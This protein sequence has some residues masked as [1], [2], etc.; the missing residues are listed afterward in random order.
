[1]SRSRIPMTMLQLIGLLS[2][3]SAWYTYNLVQWDFLHRSWIRLVDLTHVTVHASLSY[4]NILQKILWEND[5]P[6]SLLALVS[7]HSCHDLCKKNCHGDSWYTKHVR[8][9]RHPSRSQWYPQFS[10]DLHYRI[11]RISS[12]IRT[13]MVVSSVTWSLT[14]SSSSFPQKSLFFGGGKVP[15]QWQTPPSLRGLGSVDKSTRD[16]FNDVSKY[17]CT[18]YY[19]Y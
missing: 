8:E 10:H 5:L 14:S 15:N 3:R 18:L 7:F 11:T 1:L 2:K 4:T 13:P 16:V 9:T 6:G 12:S 19:L 17:I